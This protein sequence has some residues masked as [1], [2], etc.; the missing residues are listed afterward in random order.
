MSFPLRYWCESVLVEQA[1]H[2]YSVGRLYRLYVN[3]GPISICAR[4]SNRGCIRP[5]LI[6]Y[7]DDR[8]EEENGR[9]RSVTQ[10]AATDPKRNLTDFPSTSPI[11][12]L[13]S[14]HY[15][16]PCTSR[17]GSPGLDQRH[18]QGMSCNSPALIFRLD[19][20]THAGRCRR[21]V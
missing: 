13:C 8:Y 1:R 12:G 17:D 6:S 4:T 3:V 9:Q 16:N 11:C 19:F 20:A 5:P 18:V 2:A 7:A 14:L 15:H 21:R 10:P